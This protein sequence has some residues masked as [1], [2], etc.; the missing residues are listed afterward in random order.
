MEIEDAS[1]KWW[2]APK[3]TLVLVPL[4]A[5]A[6][7]ICY[8]VGY[9]AQVNI[10]YFTFFSLSEHIV[11]ALEVLP[12]ALT[13]ALGFVM[14][15]VLSESRLRRKNPAVRAEE[16]RAE[17][18]RDNELAGSVYIIGGILFSLACAVFAAFFLPLSLSILLVIFYMYRA[19]RLSSLNKVGYAI[20]LVLL[21]MLAPLGLGHDLALIKKYSTRMG[22]IIVPTSGEAMRANVVRSGDRGVV[23]Y[24]SE[25]RVNLIRWENIKQIITVDEP[26]GAAPWYVRQL[27]R[28]RRIIDKIAP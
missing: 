8:D 1:Q 23:F 25:R 22:S 9:F 3:E 19:M 7:A 14:W 10:G 18:A 27:Q 20:T 11:F 5:T 12:F 16:E 13:A 28:L 4:L 26:P 24:D 2:I 21:V 15:W 17:K 6:L